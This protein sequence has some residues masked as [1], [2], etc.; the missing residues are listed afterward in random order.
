MCAALILLW[1]SI[2]VICKCLSRRAGILAG[3]APAPDGLMTMDNNRQ[4]TPKATIFVMVCAIII[5]CSGVIFLVRGA[6]SVEN[7]FDDLDKTTD[8]VLELEN[9]IVN[10]ADD[11][12]DFAGNTTVLRDDFAE[13]IKNDKPLCTTQVPSFQVTAEEINNAAEEVYDAITALSDFATNEL[14]S[15]R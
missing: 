6:I 2:V 13:L 4:R 7:I 14:Q 10:T 1:L 11:A 3:Y 8:R 12:I 9:L 5:A 15:M